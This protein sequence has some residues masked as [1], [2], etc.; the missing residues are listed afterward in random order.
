MGLSVSLVGSLVDDGLERWWWGALSS[1]LPLDDLLAVVIL[2]SAAATST[3]TA[4]AFAVA[5]TVV[6]AREA[7][8]VGCW[9][10]VV[11]GLVAVV[12]V[13]DGTAGVHRGK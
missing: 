12:S 4:T 3:T 9:V 13:V 2:V 10:V 7:G 6:E 8:A 11:E 1:W 5:A